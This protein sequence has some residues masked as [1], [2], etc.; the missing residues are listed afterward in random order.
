MQFLKKIILC[1]LAFTAMTFADDLSYFVDPDKPKTIQEFY[2]KVINAYNDRRYEL[3]MYYS[4]KLINNYEDSPLAKEANYFLGVALYHHK[5]YE[6]ANKSFSKYLT[7]S[8]SPKY[9]EDAIIY[10]YFIAEKFATGARAHIFGA[11]ALPRWVPNDDEAI[12]IYDE[13]ISS[14]PHHEYAAKALFA[15]GKLKTS[16]QEY[17][18]S[19]ETFDLLIVRFPKHQLAIDSFVE[20]ARVYLSQMMPN[21]QNF[22]LLDS[23]EVNFRKFKKAF[24]GED[25]KLKKVRHMIDEMKEIYAKGLYDVGC[26][27]ER[28]RKDLAAKIYFSKI[29]TIF[30]KTEYAVKARKRLE[31]LK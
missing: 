10:K 15:K 22:D 7:K 16:Y 21:Q 1:S 30:P 23:A 19:L 8:M 24:P 4:Q 2:S 5:S 11:K 6:E 3:L 12:K 17:T 14:L 13:V 27:F 31:I 28:T 20:I 9:F 25:K 18:E 29:L 26:F